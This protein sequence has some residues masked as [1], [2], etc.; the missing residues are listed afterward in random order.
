MGRKL[1]DRLALNGCSSSPAPA[2]SRLCQRRG[3]SGG[4]SR[5]NSL[6]ACPA[7]TAH[8]QLLVFLKYSGG[9]KFGRGQLN[10]IHI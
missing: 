9:G 10:A 2:S 1:G 3:G 4:G 6:A 5:E 8:G 7:G